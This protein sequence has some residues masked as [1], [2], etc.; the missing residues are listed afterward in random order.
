[1][2]K[3][4]SSINNSFEVNENYTNELNKLEDSLKNQFIEV[5]D[6]L[7][8]HDSEINLLKGEFDRFKEIVEKTKEYLLLELESNLDKSKQIQSESEN[9]YDELLIYLKNENT[10]NLLSLSEENGKYKQIIEENEELIKISENKEFELNNRM[11]DL[12]EK[13]SKLNECIE[14]K[15]V[16]IAGLSDEVGGLKECIVEKDDLISS[17]NGRIEEVV[18][19]GKDKDNQISVLSD[20]LN[21]LKNCIIE[22]D[23]KNKILADENNLIKKTIVEKDNQ[24]DSFKEEI[25]IL[26]S[27]IEEKDET[28][29]SLMGD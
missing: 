5:C 7:N 28:I 29:N 18:G 20:E 1:M 16:K 22:K 3:Q 8:G 12:N 2:T 13:I 6:K 11:H 23:N 21:D 15:D 24:I 25:I 17:L 14:D 19:L 10:A 27:V 4:N 9:K 26:K